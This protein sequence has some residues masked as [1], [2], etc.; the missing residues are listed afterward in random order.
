MFEPE[1]LNMGDSPVNEFRKDLPAQSKTQN[2][3]PGKTPVTDN[4]KDEENASGNITES[5]TFLAPED[6]N[7]PPESRVI[8]Q[9][10][11]APVQEEGNNIYGEPLEINQFRAEVKNVL[12]KQ[13]GPVHLNEKTH[14]DP[15]PVA[16]ERTGKFPAS[17]DNTSSANTPFAQPA[18]NSDQTIAPGQPNN[19]RRLL[20]DPDAPVFLNSDQTFVSEQ[21]SNISKNDG[22]RFNMNNG[23]S[24]FNRSIPLKSAPQSAAKKPTIKVT[25]GQIDVRAIPEAQ[26]ALPRSKS[27]TAPGMS[28]DDYLKMRNTNKK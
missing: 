6:N 18:L 20:K 24:F 22:S 11:N 25:I 17:N 10:P 27:V 12:K 14:N 7:N 9:K 15:S 8:H 26:P 28:L 5:I 13:T 3:R 19:A 4:I 16:N 23:A 21:V 1:G 2:F